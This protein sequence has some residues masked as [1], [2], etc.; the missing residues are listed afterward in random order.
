[1]PWAVLGTIRKD[2]WPA[3]LI[4]LATLA[5]ASVAAM[6]AVVFWLSFADGLPGDPALTYTLKHYQNILLDGFTYTVLWNTLV[7]SG[8]SLMVSLLF[9]LPLAWLIERTD[10]PGKPVVFTFMTTGLLIPGFAVALG[11]VFLLHPRIGIFNQAMMTLFGMQEAPFNIASVIGMGLIEGLSL[12][13]VVFI[14]TSIVFRTMDASFEESARMS[15]ATLWQTLWEVTLPLARPGIMAAS[16]YVFAI[17]FAAFDVPAVIGL[18]GRIY[19][20][21]TYVFQ[22]MNPSEGLPEYGAVATLGMI[23]VLLALGLSLWYGKLQGQAPRFAV[24]TGKAYRLHVVR[25]GRWKA[26]IIALVCG[27]FCLTQ[28]LPLAMLIWASGLPY[29][30]APSAQAFAAFSLKNYFSLPQEQVLVGMKNTAILMV[31]VPT[32]T[33]AASV[34]ISWVVVRSRL[35]FRG[36]FDFFAFLPH[37]VPSIVFSIAAWLLALFV[38]RGVVPI[39]GTVWIL[40]IVYVIVR[41]SYGT[42]MVNSALIQ[43]H[44]ELDESARMSGATTG[45]VLQGVLLP[46][47]TPTLLYAWIWI[48]LLTYRELTLAVALATTNNQ[49]LSVVV[50]TLVSTSSYGMA[51][52]V[53]IVMLLLMLPILLLYW[54]VARRVGLVAQT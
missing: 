3:A 19:T 46:L 16:I 2:P 7:F 43:I 21:S 51:S 35:S 41:L 37:T 50:W 39:Y 31:L 45:G 4:T 49:P 36:V 48:A 27:Y 8:V 38:L 24:V 15:G 54:I 18:S 17:G 12:S 34:A 29:L 30:Q 22:Q 53:S 40:V 11:W 20:F 33:V 28:L 10:F 52:T 32:L 26:P 9:G 44:R 13:P 42:R 1:M 5:A 23:M 25:L 14:M 47:L 6:L